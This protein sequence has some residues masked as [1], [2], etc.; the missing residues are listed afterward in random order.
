MTEHLSNIP[1]SIQAKILNRVQAR[2]DDFNLTLKRYAAKRFL[3]RLGMS[4]HRSRF[5]LKGAM[6]FALWDGA[7]FCPTRDL[8]FSGYGDTST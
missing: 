2:G 6:L 8:D 4:P 5:V 7:R 1:A 3:Y